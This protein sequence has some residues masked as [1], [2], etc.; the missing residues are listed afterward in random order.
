M[1]PQGL[2]AILAALSSLV[3]CYGKII[4]ETI[5]GIQ[6]LGL[7][8]HLQAVL[9]WGFALLAVVALWRD[10]KKH[11]SSIPVVLGSIST[12]V[13]I[14]TLYVN[15]DTG[16]ETLSYVL[17]VIAAFLNQNIFLLDLNRSVMDLNK[18]VETLNEKL[19]QKVEKQVRE[20]DRL[21]RLKQ[22]LSPQVADLVIS[23]GKEDLLDIHRQYIA[24]VF[25]DIRNFTTVCEEAEPEE[26]I[27]ILQAYHD[28]LGE[29]VA[30]Y[31]GTLGY[32]AGDGLM[33]FF[34]DPVACAEPILDAVR[35]AVEARTAF[36]DIRRTWAE[37]GF[38]MGLGIG[39][40]SG[41]ATLGLVGFRGR[42]DY[43]AIGSVVN[44]A[45]RICDRADDGQILISRRAYLEL[46]ESVDARELGSFQLKGIRNEVTVYEVFALGEGRSASSDWPCRD[47]HDR[48]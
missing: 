45:S 28:R 35:L 23:E 13:L 29:L 11:R 24:C 42:S 18:K 38:A 17:L 4:A 32:R 44:I 9:M 2:V 34:N 25:C 19:V 48:L 41:H 46:E 3:T 27:E 14:G 20:I 10:R 33:V 39:V 26:I 5:F 15:Y 12:A 40:A 36:D 37:R 7:N 16:L 31:N 21:A 1:I 22:F 47:R 30:R 8:P 6:F 43:T